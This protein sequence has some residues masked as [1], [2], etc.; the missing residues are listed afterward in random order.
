M[1]KVK[2]YYCFDKHT[3]IIFQK[4]SSE[5]DEWVD[6]K[7]DEI[8]DNDKVNVIVME[9]TIN[10]APT[11]CQESLKVWFICVFLCIQ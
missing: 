11:N 8:C 2:N 1:E 7:V 4:Y 5:W 3:S 9:N 10:K 6:I